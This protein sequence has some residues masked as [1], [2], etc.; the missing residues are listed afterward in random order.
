MQKLVVETQI[1]LYGSTFAR[2]SIP[3]KYK[4]CGETAKVRGHSK[5][6]IL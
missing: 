5:A 1:K 2:H 3:L 6:E 4:R